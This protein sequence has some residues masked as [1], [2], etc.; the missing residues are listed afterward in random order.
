MRRRRRR[1]GTASASL[2]PPFIVGIGK[3][4]EKL[5]ERR[6][7]IEA[8]GS[9]VRADE[10]ATKDPRRPPRRVVA[11]K[12]VEEGDSDFGA[13]GD[14]VKADPAPFAV[15]PQPRAKTCSHA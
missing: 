15:R 12:R 4:F 13:L 8:D 10:S 1:A 2:H 11:F 14:G 5:T 3:P 6:L 9:R 7:G